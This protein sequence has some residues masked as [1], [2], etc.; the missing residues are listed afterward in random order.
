M[1]TNTSPRVRPTALGALVVAASALT[2]CGWAGDIADGLDPSNSKEH[3]VESGA[4]GKETGLL[5]GWIPDD[6]SDVSVMQRTTGSERLLTFRHSGRVPAECLPIESAGSP[7]TAELE[8]A[9]ATDLRTQEWP[10]QD[11]TTVPTLEADWWPAGQ[12]TRTTHLCGRWWVSQEA[13]TFYGFAAS[14]RV[15]PGA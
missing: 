14:Q 4:E 6:A 12:E 5:A 3:H 11:W 7:T 8:E 10:V 2:G 9:Y 15:E 13:E 1:P